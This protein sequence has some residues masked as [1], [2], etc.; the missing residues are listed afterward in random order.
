MNID[1]KNIFVTGNPGLYEINS[2]IPIDKAIL[3]NN[4]H[5]IRNK[6]MIMVV[7]HPETLSD[8][9]KNIINT[10]ILFDSLLNIENFNKTNFIFIHSNADNFNNHIFE[11][12][13]SFKYSN[14][15]SYSSLERDIYLNL[16]HYCDLFIG[17]SSSGIYEVP[18]FKKITLNIGDRQRGREMGNSVINLDFDKIQ[19]TNKINN[20]LDNTFKINQIISPY[21]ILDSSNLIA[22]LL[23]QLI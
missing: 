1:S 20:I 6:Y 8:Y 22:N 19:I 18:F 7:Y 13:N 16:L 12:I 10:D 2:F 14:I 21:K 5:I 15:Y 11:K 9:S 4:L 23:K 17:N 3:Y